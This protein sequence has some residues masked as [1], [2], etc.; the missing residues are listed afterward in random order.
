MTYQPPSELVE[1]LLSPHVTPDDVLELLWGQAEHIE[2]DHTYNGSA[3]PEAFF[4]GQADLDNY[5][6]AVAW[7]PADVPAQWRCPSILMLCHDYWDGHPAIG[8][9]FAERLL[10][11]AAPAVEWLKEQ[12]R[13]PANPNESEEQRKAR[14]VQE[15]NAARRKTGEVADAYQ[16]YLEGCRQRKLAHEKVDAEFA[17]RIAALLDAY[18]RLKGRDRE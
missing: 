15:R 9:T 3:P 16:A 6:R 18:N 7:W 1:R 10:K 13:D 4:A 11:R 14:K 12:G 17:P 8:A 5:W 2:R